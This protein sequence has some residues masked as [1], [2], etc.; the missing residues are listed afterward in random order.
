MFVTALHI[1]YTQES[2]DPIFPAKSPYKFPGGT[3][4]YYKNERPISRPFACIDETLFCDPT[5]KHCWHERERMPNQVSHIAK[6]PSYWF[7]VNALKKSNTYDSIKLRLGS[8]LLAQ[9]RVGEARSQTLTDNHWETE[10]EHMF[11]TSLA[12]AQFDAWSLA[13]G[14]D[15]DQDTYINTVEELA[16]DMCGLF[17]FRAAGYVN[18][19]MWPFW[20]LCSVLPITFLLS[21]EIKTYRKMMHDTAHWARTLL[22]RKTSSTRSDSAAAAM[23]TNQE[24]DDPFVVGSTPTTRRSSDTP[25]APSSTAAQQ[26]DLPNL[27]S[28]ADDSQTPSNIANDE[29]LRPSTP[30]PNPTIPLIPHSAQSRNN[31]GTTGAAYSVRGSRSSVHTEQSASTVNPAAQQNVN[32]ELNSQA[33]DNVDREWSPLLVHGP[34]LAAIHV[35]KSIGKKKS[36]TVN[37]TTS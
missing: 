16:D 35:V 2:N 22:S 37:N 1:V 33:N 25:I 3:V 10:V 32:D 21:V 27:P 15:H 9:Q 34:I 4:L 5:N 18:I 30:P 7:M 31:Y 8:S 12:R 11:K 20:L 28:S 26:N 23:I 19:R 6:D 13:S 17:K 24:S 29:S 14:E 36:D